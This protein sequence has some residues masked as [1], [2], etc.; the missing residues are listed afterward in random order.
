MAPPTKSANSSQ[1]NFLLGILDKAT[2]AVPGVGIMHSQPRTGIFQTAKWSC[3]RTTV[4]NATAQE[5]DADTYR[6][7]TSEGLKIPSPISK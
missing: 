5:D 4:Q 1:P 6:V 2:K 7:F 3:D